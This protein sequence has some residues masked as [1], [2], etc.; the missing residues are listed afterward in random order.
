MSPDFVTLLLLIIIAN[1]TPVLVRFIFNK[2]LDTA[3]D[4][5]AILAD[6]QRLFGSSKTWRGVAGAVL[7]TSLTAWLLDYSIL[8]GCKIALLALLGDLLSSFTK[9]RLGLKSGGMAPLLDQ[10][11]ESLLPAI[12]L[13]NEFGL[14]LKDVAFIVISFIVLEL[15]LSRIFF[16]LGVRRSPY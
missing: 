2:H 6:G 5:G 8:T 3:I 13:M 10:V 12:I 1:S 9:R 14:G 7:T 16:I 4:F 11:P 15:L